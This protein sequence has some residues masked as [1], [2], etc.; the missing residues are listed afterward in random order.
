M[1]KILFILAIF[2]LSVNT[3]FATPT[4]IT[5]NRLIH[6]IAYIESKHNPKLVSSNGLYVGY[7]QI[8]KIAVNECNRLIGYKK[9]NY[10]DRYDKN[11]SIEMFH[12]IQSYHNP[13]QDLH[14]A[15]RIWSEGTTAAN[16]TIRITP[17]VKKVLRLYNSKYS[18]IEE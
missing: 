12:I 6:T 13:K 3:T 5:Y 15:I 1:R 10:N 2:L 18:H 8:S 9:Y 11:K 17:Y 4:K 14:L 7:L 16:K